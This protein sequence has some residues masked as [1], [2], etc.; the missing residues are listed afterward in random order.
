MDTLASDCANPLAGR[1][2]NMNARGHGGQRT[3]PASL[4]PL[5]DARIPSGG[6]DGITAVV[7]ALRSNAAKILIRV[8]LEASGN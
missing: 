8:S 5:A 2:E 3:E 1:A 7:V 4:P 6:K